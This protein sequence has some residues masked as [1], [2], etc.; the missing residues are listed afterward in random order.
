MTTDTEARCLH[1]VHSPYAACPSKGITMPST[2]RRSFLRRGAAL[3][4]VPAVALLAGGAMAG[5]A[6]A[7]RPTV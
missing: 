7:A 3:A 4:A 6:S 1:D 2:K 5:Q